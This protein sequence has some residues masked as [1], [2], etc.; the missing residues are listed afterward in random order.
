MERYQKIY[1]HPVYQKMLDN[2]KKAEQNRIFCLHGTEHCLDT[3]RIAYI[4]ALEEK[5]D[6]KKD[7]I[8]AAALLH[9]IGRYGEKEHNIESAEIAVK[10]MS[11]CGYSTEERNEVTNAIRLH[12]SEN[13]SGLA[14][15]LSRADKLSRNCFECS[16][17]NECYWPEEKLNRNITY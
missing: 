4:L 6:I 11:E 12:R 14:Y 15:V 9:D 2:I 13:I 3:A 8:Y 10:I 5:L 16:A 7:I 17:I 1:K